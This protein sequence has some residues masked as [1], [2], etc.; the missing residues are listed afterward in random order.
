LVT[1]KTDNGKIINDT[2]IT[3]ESTR[4]A[5]EIKGWRGGRPG[6]KLP[7]VVLT[8]QAGGQDRFCYG[9]FQA[10]KWA[11]VDLETR[12][13]KLQNVKDDDGNIIGK[14][15]T[16]HE[17]SMKAEHFAGASMVDICAHIAHELVHLENCDLG[18]ADCSQ[19]GAH[20]KKFKERAE[21]YGLIVTHGKDYGK[22]GKA[23][24]Y[25]APG[26]EFIEFVESQVK[27]IIEAFDM[28]RV[29]NPEAD[30]KQSSMQSLKCGCTT[31]DDGKK[32]GSTLSMTR[33]EV[34]TR[35]DANELPYCKRCKQDFAPQ[36]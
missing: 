16:M 7:D 15:G 12:E 14:T 27:P 36:A 6:K 31:D 25:T 5:N 23:W 2:H 32:L 35:L 29:P 20:N 28:A 10:N 8:I 33:L 1:Y 11:R 24:A 34:Q 9:T 21:E 17:I 22:P 19:G 13:L 30:K 26:P 18:L 4:I 3:E